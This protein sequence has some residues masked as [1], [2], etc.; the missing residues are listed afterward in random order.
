M[1]LNNETKNSILTIVR[2]AFMVGF[3]LF[4][5]LSLLEILKPRI[6]LNFF[7]LDLFLM[8]LAVLGVIT[9]LFFQPQIFN[10]QGLKFMDK[11]TLFFFSVLLGLLVLFLVRGL[12]WLCVLVGLASAV[13]CYYFVSTNLNDNEEISL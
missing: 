12:G 11:I 2:D 13:I 3:V 10:R 6:A 1:K 9:I 5:V 8:I 4:A 7:S